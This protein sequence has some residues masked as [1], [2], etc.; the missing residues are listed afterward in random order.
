MPRGSRNPLVLSL[1]PEPTPLESQEGTQLSA[2]GKGSPEGDALPH[3]G[4]PAAFRGG[5]ANGY[6]ELKLH[7]DK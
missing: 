7:D 5:D 1:R 4:V 6:L 2:P 3:G